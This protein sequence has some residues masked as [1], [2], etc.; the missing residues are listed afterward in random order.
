MKRLLF[1]IVLLYALGIAGCSSENQQTE[2]AATTLPVYEF[3]TYLCQ[4]TPL[5]VT[6]L[7]TENVSCLHDYTLQTR[8]MRAAESAQLLILSG[9]GLDDFMDN[10]A[11]QAHV[12]VNCAEGVALIC[13]EEEHDHEQSTTH[14]HHHEEDPHIWL[15][16]ANAKTMA[17]NIYKGL[18]AQYPEFKTTFQNNLDL[19]NQKLDA[20][21]QYGNKQLK[22]LSS[23]DLITF[24]DGFSYLAQA[25]DLTVLHAIEEESGSEASAGEL[26]EI[27]N[28]IED[29]HIHSIFT[30]ANG[31]VSAAEIIA[32][33][34]GATMFQLDM[35][36]G[37]RGYFDAMYHNID[38]FKEALE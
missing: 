4:G 37:E 8:Q 30:E 9:A 24:H 38:T 29:H 12:T 1:Y 35:C 6:R 33:E 26:I 31:S 7:V 34:T 13:G 18:S 17:E 5:T 32:S 25:F 11:T 23:K 16:P 20:L 15:S 36:M 10:I 14:G 2:I 27:I 19:L 3:A 28:L 22:D 21:E